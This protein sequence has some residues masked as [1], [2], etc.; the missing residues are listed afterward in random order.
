LTGELLG[1]EGTVAPAPQP[2]GSLNGVTPVTMAMHIHALDEYFG[3]MEAQLAEATRV[4]VDT[5]WWTNHDWRLSA[6]H[7]R[8]MVHFD[9]LADE[10]QFGAAWKWTS[11]SEG[12]TRTV[13]WFPSTTPLARSQGRA[14]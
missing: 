12:C 9:S 3:C 4:G 14:L 13:G 6:S 10:Q 2:L 11:Q 1:A 7:Y 5:V 8:T